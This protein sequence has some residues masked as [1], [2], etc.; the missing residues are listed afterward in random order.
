MNNLVFNDLRYIELN[1]WLENKNPSKLF[2]LVDENTFANCLPL[3]LQEIA[4]E[5]PI[6]ILEIEPGESNKVIETCNQLWISLLELNADR[7]SAIINIG[8]GVVTDLG[9]FLAS[10][11][12]RGI[13]FINIPTSLLAMVD[14]S[15]GGKTGIDIENVK[16]AVGTFSLPELTI[17]NSNFLQTLPNNQLKSGFAEMLKHALIADKNHWN[18]LKNLKE[19]STENISPFIEKSVSI[20]KNIVE[21]DFKETGLRKT[22]NFGHT[23]GHAIESFSLHSKKPLLHGEAI[24]IGMYYETKLSHQKNML[25][26][27]DYIEITSVITHFFSDELHYKFTLN[28]IISF[29]KNDKKNQYNTIMM[30]LLT[31]IGNCQIDCLAEFQSLQKIF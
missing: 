10:T 27:D 9:G 2:F 1:T 26:D 24:A 17:I 3:V 11:F 25:S 5:I 30:S 8:G 28:D 31:E 20:K 13:S 16:N 23:I 4:T 29:M 6:E 19:I 18:E 21:K 15:I 12:M 7:N 14:A 22:L